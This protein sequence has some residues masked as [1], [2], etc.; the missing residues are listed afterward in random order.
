MSWCDE[1]INGQGP[2]ARNRHCR[3][4]QIYY[5]L[6]IVLIFI[7]I[8]HFSKVAHKRFVWDINCSQLIGWGSNIWQHLVFPQEQDLS[9]GQCFIFFL[10]PFPVFKWS[11]CINFEIACWTWKAEMSLWKWTCA[12]LYVKVDTADICIL[13]WDQHEKVSWRD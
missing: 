13:F 10:F 11:F 5:L 12:Q 7:L 9:K 6:F 3:N 8:S 2:S 4:K 1:L